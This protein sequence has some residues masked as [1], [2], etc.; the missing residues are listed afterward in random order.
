M[1]SHQSLGE[2]PFLTISAPASPGCNAVELKQ[3]MAA[4]PEG[5]PERILTCDRAS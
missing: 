4:L 2:P 1:S 5:T 3:D